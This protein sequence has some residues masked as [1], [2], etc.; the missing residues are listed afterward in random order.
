MRSVKSGFHK[1]LLV[2]RQTQN[3]GLS[4]KT[5]GSAIADL[6]L[7]YVHLVRNSGPYFL[8]LTEH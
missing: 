8:A 1:E 5:V 4:L 7:G 6:I 2:L 3:D